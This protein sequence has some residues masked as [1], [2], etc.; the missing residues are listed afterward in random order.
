MTKKTKNI[1]LVLGF[2]LTLIICYQLAIVKTIE[3]NTEYKGLKHQESFFKNTPKQVSIL[4]Q[5]ERYY[6]SLLTKLQLNGSSIQNNLLKTINRYAELNNL[7][8]ISFLEP[9]TILK[10]DLTIK[11]YNFTLEGNYNNIINL[12]YQLEQKTKFGEVIN[13]HFEKKKNFRTG[14]HYLQAKVLLKSFG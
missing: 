10:N 7:K 3:L 4:K 1:L 11:T 14:K 8:L 2:L 13:L 5:K 6:D 9:H 12:I